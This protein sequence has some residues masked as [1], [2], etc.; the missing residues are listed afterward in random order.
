MLTVRFPCPERLTA[1]LARQEGA[2][3]SYA[4]V[5][6]TRGQAPPGWNADTLREQI[7]IGSEAFDRACEALRAWVPQRLG[8]VR[9]HPLDKPPAEGAVVALTA[10]VG[11]FRWTNPCRVVETFDEAG[12]PRRFGFA[13]GSLAE[14]FERGEA[15]FVV[16]LSDDGAVWYE[17]A[18]Y[19]RP[20]HWLA[21]LGYPVSRWYQRR[22]V[23]GSL[24]AMKAAVGSAGAPGVAS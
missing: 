16:E 14:H 17:L 15:R 22:F 20:R 8:W 2:E 11:V 18:I 1:F 19:S 6:M 4:P 3:L 9:P 7:G 24:A 10:R 13:Y 12:P 21:R 5:G 23:R